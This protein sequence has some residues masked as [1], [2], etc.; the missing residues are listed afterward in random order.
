MLTSKLKKSY[1]LYSSLEKE[2]EFKKDILIINSIGIL[3]KIYQYGTLCYIGGGMGNNGLHNILEPAIY[4]LPIIIGKNYS[5][6]SEAKD[7]ISI[8]GVKSIKNNKEF[9]RIFEKIITDNQLSSKI[10]EINKTYILKNKGATD[11][12]FIKIKEFL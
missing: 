6:F 1:A 8:G 10:G 11:K 3:S 2:K 5:K 7:L 12:I 4:G 9:E